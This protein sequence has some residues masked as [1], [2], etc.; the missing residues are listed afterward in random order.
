[1]AQFKTAVPKT[2][3]P[4]WR[5]REQYQWHSKK[6]AEN[7]SDKKFLKKYLNSDENILINHW[8]YS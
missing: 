3:T 7:L 6:E 5:P 2:L 4:T 8:I 1:M